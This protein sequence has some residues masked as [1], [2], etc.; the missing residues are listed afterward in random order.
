MLMTIEVSKAYID[1]SIVNSI[2]IA[3]A[4]CLCII[5]L[6]ILCAGN[7]IAQSSLYTYDNQ[8]RLISDKA[9]NITLIEWSNT[10]KI[11]RIVTPQHVVEFVY[12]NVDDRVK[13][14]VKPKN[15]NGNLLPQGYW[16][17]TYY[18][19]D[20]K[21][22]EVTRY[23]R[24]YSTEGGGKYTDTFSQTDNILDGGRRLNAQN[25]PLATVNFTATD[26]GV[27][28][29][30]IVYKGLLVQPAKEVIENRRGE[31]QYDLSDHASNNLSS[32]SDRKKEHNTELI[33]AQ[34]YYPYGMAQP[35]RTYDQ[36]A[37]KFGYAGKETDP[38]IGGIRHSYNFGA[39]LYD[40]RVARW[41]SV[42]KLYA[43]TPQLS[44]YIYS[45]SSPLALTDPDG[46]ET[47]FTVL[48]NKDKKGGT[49]IISTE[50]IIRNMPTATFI[51]NYQKLVNH[52]YTPKTWVDYK[53][54]HR[55]TIKFDISIMD[56]STAFRKLYNPTTSTFK[57]SP[58]SL[59]S[60]TVFTH[61]DRSNM[62]SYYVGSTVYT[63][64]NFAD[65][66]SRDAQMLIHETGHHL[67]LSDRYIESDPEKKDAS[68]KKHTELSKSE[69]AEPY[70]E[71]D[72]MDGGFFISGTHFDNWLQ[73]ALKAGYDADKIT[74]NLPR[75]Q[76]VDLK[77]GKLTPYLVIPY[78]RNRDAYH[79][80]KRGEELR[81]KRQ[82]E[83][84]VK[85]SG[86]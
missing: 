21:G 43:K 5:K 53:T 57:K 73:A 78:V 7:S 15:E 65:Y 67:G 56:M 81:Q 59:S 75:Y 8:G 20:A 39:R 68:D 70:M 66:T 19:Y 34:D 63:D 16:Q 62:D 86:K 33:F 10:N 24:I 1:F 79:S 83:A 54:G 2:R 58:Q 61:E 49:V 12:N 52:Y 35:S 26:N 55:W 74:V 64:E 31:K 38:Q 22:K 37:F 69:A 85:G 23:E 17:Y 40:P 29:E 41:W 3:H 72:L 32:I 18:S 47:V 28:F 6:L 76:F 42:D 30:N 50:I 27:T 77:D 80:I 11:L 48:P 36:A 9:N 82:N 60:A 13:K 71:N 45:E 4:T 84:A 14:I 51:A 46:N 25:K 44:P